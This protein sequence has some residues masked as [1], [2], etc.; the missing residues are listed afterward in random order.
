MMD[1][2]IK[3]SKYIQS[4]G[5]L[6]PQKCEANET[7]KR[8]Q[9][10]ISKRNTNSLIEVNTEKF[11]K[12]SINIKGYK[13]KN[14]NIIL[15]NVCFNIEKGDLLII[16][17]ESGKGKTTLLKLIS[18]FLDE[19]GLD[20]K[21]LYNDFEISKYKN[22][23]YYKH[24]LQVEQNIV[25]IEGTL[26]ENIFMGDN[27]L[28]ED[29]EEIIYTCVLE[30]FLENKEDNFVIKEHGKNISGGEKQRIGLARTLIRK[31]EV[32]ILDEITSGLDQETKEELTERLVKFKQ[33]Y[34]I[35]LIV[36]SHD[37]CFDGFK[38]VYKN[39]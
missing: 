11:E 25:L 15:K 17:G 21:I 18:K 29:F 33:K 9:D 28:H 2:T 5:N 10:V 8:I 7:Y 30:K 24:V 36:V 32:V 26:K 14:E 38:I 19:K 34:N 16:K 6:L 22:L 1:L 4:I 31:P 3:I 35:T 37:N 39:L 27:F 23:D 20:G 13:F 12:L